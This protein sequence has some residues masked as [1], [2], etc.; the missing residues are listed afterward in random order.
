MKIHFRCDGNSTVCSSNREHNALT[1]KRYIG[2][3]PG[4]RNS[5]YANELIEVCDWHFTNHKDLGWKSMV[6]ACKIGCNHIACQEAYTT[7]KDL[8]NK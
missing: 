4:G 7:N 6:L 3:N 8:Y 5:P 1:I 2:N